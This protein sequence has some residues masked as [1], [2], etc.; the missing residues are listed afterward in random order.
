MD[1]FGSHRLAAVLLLPLA[2]AQAPTPYC[3]SGVSTHGCTPTV[4]ANVQPDTSNSAGCVITTSGL[5]GRKRGLSFY[6]VDNSAFSPIPWASGS[7]SFLCVKP[8]TLRLGAPMDSGGV[9]GQCDGSFIV[10]WDAFQSAHP[11][12]LG[13]PWTTGRNV[14]VQSWY[15][16]PTAPA[17]SNLSNALE[18]T[19]RVPAPVPCATT[20]SGMA[21]IP[22]GTFLMGSNAANG[23][24]YYNEYASAQPVHAVTISYCFWMAEHEVTQTE[25][26]ALLGVNPSWFP[27]ADLP[28]Q[29]V[30]WSLARAYCAALSAQQSAAGAVPAGYEYRLPTEAEWEYACRAGSTSEFNVGAALLCSDATFTYSSHSNSFCSVTRPAPVGSYAPNAWGLYDMHG[31]VWEW[32]LDSLSNYSATPVT[33]PFV[34]GGAIRVLRGGSYRD[35]SYFCRSAMRG[36]DSDSPPAAYGIVGLRV[37][38]APAL[39][40]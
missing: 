29:S 20:I 11:S 39:A 21:L 1:S 40:P 13:N 3:T 5:E 8:P 38:L 22:A 33:D 16:D 23:P 2:H 14:F 30:T 9:V 32:C 31:N 19:L 7:A 35:S 12:S 27:G 36:G 28:V 6:G 10:D 25:F 17:H 15:R 34:T 37:V 18:L 24:P 4:S 26:T